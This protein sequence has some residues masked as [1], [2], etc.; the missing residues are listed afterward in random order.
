[1]PTPALESVEDLRQLGTPEELR[2]LATAGLK[3]ERPLRVNSH[4][5]LPPNFSAFDTVGDAVAAAA[6]EDV[7]VLG[8]SNY[9]DYSVYHRFTA[10]A[11]RRGI[12]PLFGLEIIVLDEGLVSQGVRVNDPKN[13]GK[14]YLCGKGITRFDRLSEEGRRILDL[15]RHKDSTRMT[16]MV[17]RME[18][19][20]AN[21]ELDT[22]LNSAA[23]VDGVTRRHGS[24]RG[25]VYLQERHAAQAFQEWLFANR[26]GPDRQEALAV[27]LGPAAASVS[28]DDSVAVQNALRDVL[29]KAGR[30][31]YVAE[32]FVDYP[33]ARRLIL[34]M[35]GIPCYPTLADG[36]SDRCEFEQPVEGLLDRMAERNLYCAEFIP[37]RNSPEVLRQYAGA[38]RSR[39]IVVT[40]GT[41][42]NTLSR[43]PME[44]TCVKGQPIPD[45]LKALFWEGACVVAAHQVLTLQCEAGY[46]DSE[47]RL[48]PGYADA[49]ARIAAFRALGEAIFSRYQQLFPPIG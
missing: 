24:P 38:M 49:E 13:P 17:D 35:G 44:P 39:G 11:G 32:T 25:T 18:V 40:A 45:D 3:P 21:H 2:A 43:D 47:G 19:F 4:V 7:R 8:V 20:F 41:E 6:Q 27:L 5:H 10:E 23:V 26:Q 29:M 48:R 31:A 14:M 16:E 33:Q 22:G 46:V 34:E 12:F 28:P 9:Y 30:P 1:M 37:T 42:H 15:I 36:A